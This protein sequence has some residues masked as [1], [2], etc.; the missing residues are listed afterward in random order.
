V[1]VS[2]SSIFQKW[3]TC[4]SIG[5]NVVFKNET[6]YRRDRLMKTSVGFYCYYVMVIFVLVER[7]HITQWVGGCGCF[8]PE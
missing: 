7:A 3:K 8:R 4:K 1:D 2:S 6:Q 5:R